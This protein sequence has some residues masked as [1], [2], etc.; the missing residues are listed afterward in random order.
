MAQLAES[1]A[2]VDFTQGLDCRLLTE[3]NIAAINRIRLKD[4]HFAWDSME[5]TGA[6]LEK[7][8]FYAAL[9]KRRPHGK[10]ATVYMLTNFGTTHE[11]DLYRVE[12]LRGLGYDP[13]VMVFDKPHAP[14]VTRQLQRWVNNRRIFRA[15]SSFEDFI[16]HNKKKE[17]SPA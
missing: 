9:A 14:P 16:S 15:V 13:F 17:V 5:E 1:H 6:V 7:L 2:Y 11:Q 8:R 4:I 10:F 3:D 12:V